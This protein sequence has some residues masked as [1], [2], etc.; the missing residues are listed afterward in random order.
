MLVY[1]KDSFHYKSERD[2]PLG[3]LELSHCTGI[4]SSSSDD[5]IFTVRSVDTDFTLKARF[6][7]SVEGWKTAIQCSWDLAR[8]DIDIQ[9]DEINEDSVLNQVI[10]LELKLHSLTSPD[11]EIA[12]F[13]GELTSSFTVCNRFIDPTQSIL[14]SFC[15]HSSLDQSTQLA[16][17]LARDRFNAAKS[18][19]FS[20]LSPVT[21][22]SSS[23]SSDDEIDE[24]ASLQFDQDLKSSVEVLQ[25]P[26]FAPLPSLA[27]VDIEKVACSTDLIGF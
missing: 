20:P 8:K 7:D 26:S 18:P 22:P 3:M 17:Q 21:S 13:L 14:D 4:Y 10:D 5:R 1:Y 2:T 27:N 24:G 25:S 23:S 15:S 6:E 9:D 12:E 19:D 16:F 11:K